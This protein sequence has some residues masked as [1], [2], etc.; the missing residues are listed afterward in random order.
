MKD[1]D[2]WEDGLILRLKEHPVLKL[3]P[4][5][6]E[7]EFTGLL[8]QRR[9]VSLAFTPAYDLAIDLLT[10]EAAKQAARVILREEYPDG[11]GRT[12]SHREDMKEDLLALGVSRGRL[13]TTRPTPA[14]AE[15]ITATMELIADCGAAPDSDLRLVTMLRLWGEILVSVEY[16]AF[17]PRMKPVFVRDG[18]NHSRFYH[19]HYV[20]DEKTTP[21]SQVSLLSTTHS[22]RLAVRL[23][24]LLAR[25]GGA[26]SFREVEERALAVKLGF[27]AQFAVG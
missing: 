12:P 20:H 26:A 5:L 3:V 4:S 19:P 7:E 15:A 21:L 17:W 9:F 10:D 11:T 8:L 22:D 13:V 6:G 1:L 16:G 25:D 23:A 24:D 2:A 27:Y 14:T 18:R